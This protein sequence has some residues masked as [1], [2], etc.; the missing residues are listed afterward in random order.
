[1]IFESLINSN[2][3]FSI[4]SKSHFN[5]YLDVAIVYYLHSIHIGMYLIKHERRR[6]RLTLNLNVQLNMSKGRSILADN[7]VR[8]SQITKNS[9]EEGSSI[10]T[11]WDIT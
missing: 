11:N 5:K 3:G 2:F 1:M 8:T 4:V 6:L 9:S 7:I 10:P